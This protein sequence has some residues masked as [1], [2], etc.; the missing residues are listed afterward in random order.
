MHELNKYEYVNEHLKIT[1]REYMKI[2]NVSHT[3]AQKELKDLII[4]KVFRTSGAGKY[5]YYELT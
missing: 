1:R 3:T 5:T 2:N 4:K